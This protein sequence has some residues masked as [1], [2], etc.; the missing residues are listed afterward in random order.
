MRG[1]SICHLENACNKSSSFDRKRGGGGGGRQGELGFDFV[2][3]FVLMA[4]NFP[5]SRIRNLRRHS[6]FHFLTGLQLNG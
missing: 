5:H 1:T 6:H 4:L 2:C 3:L